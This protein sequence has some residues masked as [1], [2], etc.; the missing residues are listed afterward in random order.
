MLKGIN[1][2]KEY[3]GTAI[4]TEK[5]GSIVY[6]DSKKVEPEEL[7]KDKYEYNNWN[8]YAEVNLDDIMLKDLTI[9]EFKMVLKELLIEMEGNIL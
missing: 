7:I 6:D 9:S 2:Y 1:V 4:Q 8:A 3:T 5:V